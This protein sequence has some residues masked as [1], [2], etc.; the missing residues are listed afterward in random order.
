MVKSVVVL[1]DMKRSVQKKEV[2]KKEVKKKT[3]PQKLTT[4]LQRYLE[5][6]ES[7]P[8]NEGKC[9]DESSYWQQGDNTCFIASTFMIV[10]R[11]RVIRHIQAQANRG[12]EIARETLEMFRQLAKNDCILRKT[13]GS[14]QNKCPNIPIEIRKRYIQRSRDDVFSTGGF[15]IFM[16]M[17]IFDACD[18]SFDVVRKTKDDSDEFVTISKPTLVIFKRA[19]GEKILN[20]FRELMLLYKAL[21]KE[22]FLGCI[23]SGFVGDVYHAFTVLVCHEKNNIIL[24]DSKRRVCVELNE[25]S[26]RSLYDRYF[27]DYREVMYIFMP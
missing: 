27:Q 21:Y 6:Y 2:Q 5:L 9:G 3:L 14:P 12:N 13:I 8:N 10:Y 17:A 1:K 11:T 24:C 20:N 25:V 22:H 19:K 7:C 18:I 26:A 23:V 15:P 16:T 4:E